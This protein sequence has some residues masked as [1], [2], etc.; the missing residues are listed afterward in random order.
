MNRIVQSVAHLATSTQSRFADFLGACAL[1]AINSYCISRQFIPL[2]EHTCLCSGHR[3]G[4]LNRSCLAYGASWLKTAQQL[5]LYRQVIMRNAAW[6][7]KASAGTCKTRSS[8]RCSHHY[9]M[10]KHRHI[11]MSS[12]HS[13]AISKTITQAIAMRQIAKCNNSNPW[14]DGSLFSSDMMVRQQMMLGQMSNL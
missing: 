4:G 10:H 5:D 6:H 13:N 9:S 2:Y 3:C 8:A 7:T 11:L 12:R 14:S 1:Y